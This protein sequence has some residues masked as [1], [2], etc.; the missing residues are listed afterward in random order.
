MTTPAPDGLRRQLRRLEHDDRLDG[1]R[2]HRAGRHL[3]PLPQA[4]QRPHLAG[5]NEAAQSIGDPD[6]RFV[7]QGRDENTGELRPSEKSI[8]L[9]ETDEVLSAPP[10]K[11]D[12]SAISY[13][14]VAAEWSLRP[15]RLF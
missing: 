15:S 5:S 9:G 2:R 7:L 11:A 12:I 1:E 13:T 14:A 8:L 10:S 3:Q 6:A 4:R